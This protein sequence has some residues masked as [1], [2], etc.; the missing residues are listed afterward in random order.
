MTHA[1]G[2]RPVTTVVGLCLSLIRESDVWATWRDCG[3]PKWL[4]RKRIT[5]AIRLQ[6]HTLVIAENPVL[7]ELPFLLWLFCIN[8]RR[9]L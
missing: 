9:R 8:K 3:A 1:I 7:R 4:T 6:N 5:H 2:E